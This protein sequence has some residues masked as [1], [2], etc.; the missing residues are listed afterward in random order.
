MLY[1]PLEEG[2]PVR[3]Q[4]LTDSQIEQIPIMRQVLHLML[5]LSASELKLTAKGYI[6][7]KIVEELYLM[8]ERSW[9]DRKSV[10]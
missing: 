3:L 5:V 8:G 7:P 1:R 9:K 10:V 4:K 2:C 6:P